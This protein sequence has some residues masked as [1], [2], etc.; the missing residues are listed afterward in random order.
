MDGNRSFFDLMARLDA[1]SDTA[2]SRL[3]HLY[4]QRVIALA[5]K[6]LDARIRQKLDPE[7]VGQ[8]VFKSFFLR[9]ANGEYDLDDWDRLWALLVRITICKCLNSN[10]H[11]RWV[12][13]SV[14]AEVSAHS[15]DRMLATAW[16]FID[17]QPGPEEA[18][19][20]TESMQE[21]V[22]GLDETDS[23]II[24]MWLQ[25]YTH[26]EIASALKVPQARVQR[27][28]VRV[29]ERLQRKLPTDA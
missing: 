10:Q 27:V 17:R 11:Y 9:H 13:R 16:D 21:A 6:K 25:G 29:R 15:G 28:I 20:L 14:G 24:E 2:A 26:R 12:R 4:G 22:R 23:K 19:I 3:F 1:G 8:L 7:D 18:A 5:R